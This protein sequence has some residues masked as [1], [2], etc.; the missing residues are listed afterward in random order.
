M[1]DVLQVSNGGII[2]LR[3]TQ[4]G[5]DQDIVENIAGKT[6]RRHTL[7][8]NKTMF[9]TETENGHYSP[10]YPN[11]TFKTCQGK[12]SNLYLSHES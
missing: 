7:N 4:K 10:L 1:C 9:T 8:A 5:E 3:D 12:E 6:T 11:F 2:M